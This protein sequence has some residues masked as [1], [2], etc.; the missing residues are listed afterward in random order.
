ML[1]YYSNHSLPSHQQRLH[2]KLL[3]L[4]LQSLEVILR[5]VKALSGGH[6][7]SLG[8]PK[9]HAGASPGPAVS[10]SLIR[11]SALALLK[12]WGKLYPRRQTP[13]C[14]QP[15]ALGFSAKPL[16]PVS[17]WSRCQRRQSPLGWSLPWGM[18][19]ELPGTWEGT[20]HCCPA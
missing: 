11:A 2:F 5:R 8:L 20:Q 6:T 18:S 17:L 12:R 4:S 1:Q 13:A 19:P 7:T 16:L 10:C 9:S 3:L 15:L 14:C